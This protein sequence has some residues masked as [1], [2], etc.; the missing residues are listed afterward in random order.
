MSVTESDRFGD[1]PGHNANTNLDGIAQGI[2]GHKHNAMTPLACGH[3]VIGNLL[4]RI[5][6][7][8]KRDGI[9]QC[10]ARNSSKVRENISFVTNNR[11]LYAWFYQ[12]LILNLLY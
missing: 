1:L 3:N 12:D 8:I 9:L 7:C 4:D 10:D 11:F 6:L 5:L 2:H